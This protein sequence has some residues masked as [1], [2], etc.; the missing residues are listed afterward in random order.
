MTFWTCVRCCCCWA[1][2]LACIIRSCM[3][4]LS[5]VRPHATSEEGGRMRGMQ[6]GT[7]LLPASS[8]RPPV[9]PSPSPHPLLPPA[10]SSDA[11]AVPH[12]LLPPTS[13]QHASPSPP[14][15]ASP[16]RM[17]MIV[18]AVLSSFPPLLPAFRSNLV[19]EDKTLA[20]LLGASPLLRA[21][22]VPLSSMHAVG[23]LVGGGMSFRHKL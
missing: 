12:P 15:S 20:S 2:L 17:V 11:W 9:P 23:S 13:I 16:C 10:R 7:S 6:G 21:P 19:S 18:V 8:S 22:R 4:A 5:S 14:A 3:R 1:C